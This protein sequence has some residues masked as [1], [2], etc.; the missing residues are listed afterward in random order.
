MSEGENGE[1]KKLYRSRK[2]RVLGG[3][4]GG[5]AEYL[6]MDSTVVRLLWAIS[7]LV[8]G[9]GFLL[10]LIALFVIPNNP[11]HPEPEE[12]EATSGEEA[13]PKHHATDWNLAVGVV[14]LLL[15]VLF[16]LSQFDVFDFHYIR[17]N[18]FP[19]RLFW[20]LVLIGLGIFLVASHGTIS[21]MVD[22]VRERAGASRLHKSRTDK[23]IFGVCG[24]LGKSFSMDPTILRILWVVAALM[25]GGV[26]VLVYI[27]LALIMPYNSDEPLPSAKA[28]NGK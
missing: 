7:V 11:A 4:C 27:V 3:V 1:I 21:N 15:G 9:F 23:M 16:L 13:K 22:D 24:G 5:L 14:L 6:E 18:F 2:D 28:E 19:W 26:L 10:Y 8:F 25:S 12:R 20:P 17:F